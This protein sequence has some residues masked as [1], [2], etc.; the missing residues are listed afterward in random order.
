MLRAIAEN[1]GDAAQREH[2]HAAL[3]MSA[4]LR[5]AR[6]LTL[7]TALSMVSAAAPSL[8]RTVYDAQQKTAMRGKLVRAEG[9]KA[10]GDAAADEAYDGAG[11]T[12]D[13]YDKVLGRSSVDGRGMPLISS[14]H[15][16]VRY[17]NAM[18]NGSQMVYGDGDGK[19]F[20]RFTACLEIIG[21]ELTHGV[22]QHT[23]ALEYHDQSGA[24]NE[25]FSDVFGVLVKQYTLKQTAAKADWLIGAGLLA[26]AV[27]GDAIRSMKAPGTA[28]DDKVLGKDP[29]PAHMRD[30]RKLT[31]DNGGVHVNS[32][33]PNHAF[34]RVATLLGGKAWDVAGRIWYDALTTKLS[35]SASFRDCAAATAAAAAQR[36]GATSEPH[37]AVV[38]AWKDVGIDIAAVVTK[39][40]KLRIAADEL[41]QPPGGGA[42]A[43]SLDVQRASRRRRTAK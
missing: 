4:Q 20:N 5:G 27:H 43:P 15:Y 35:A 28:Y 37:A 3:E 31:S 25:H 19:L 13:F 41:F 11:S 36:Y 18:W 29:Q 30:Y 34:Y 7:P 6:A 33:I 42:E 12:Y 40:P 14:V 22:T 16:G 2:A 8:Q 9:G 23:A 21:H 17:D 32:G 26:T 10:T 38:Q 39:G 1:S 24:L